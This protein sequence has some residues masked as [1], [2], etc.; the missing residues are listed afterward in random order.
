MSAYSHL[1][2]I[3]PPRSM[4]WYSDIAG[5]KDDALEEGLELLEKLRAALPPD[6]SRAVDEAKVLLRSAAE[7]Y[8]EAHDA[9]RRMAADPS[10]LANLLPPDKK[11]LLI[12]LCELLAKG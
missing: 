10:A 4:A 11:R 5:E 7:L 2:P 1:P 12:E 3:K 9:Q 8:H 6:K